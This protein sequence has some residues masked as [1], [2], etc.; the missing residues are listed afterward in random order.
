[1]VH[2]LKSSA[3]MIGADGL[4]ELALELEMASEKCDE[5]SI[6]AKHSR[7][8][9][10]YERTAAAIRAFCGAEEN[11]SDS[12]EEILEFFPQQ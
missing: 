12:E 6:R 10:L 11:H 8:T 3:R 7:L 1:L 2:A 5:D 4:S 9:E